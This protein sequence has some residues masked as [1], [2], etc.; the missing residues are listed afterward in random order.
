M[1]VSPEVQAL[2]GLC[3]IIYALVIIFAA[4]WRPKWLENRFLLQRWWGFG[5]KANRCAAGL[6][7]GVWISIGA[8]LLGDAFDLIT[9]GTSYWVFALILIFFVSSVIAQLAGGRNDAA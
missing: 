5:P 1:K 9:R 7:S 3:L 4:M 6:G 2:F 8:F